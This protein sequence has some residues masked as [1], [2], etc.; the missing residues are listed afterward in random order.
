MPHRRRG[1][2]V[3]RPA[4]LGRES[5]TPPDPASAVVF[6]LA[7]ALSWTTGAVLSV[8]GGLMADRNS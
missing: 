5:G 3:E 4:P 8:D 7:S 2:A 6:L 1:G